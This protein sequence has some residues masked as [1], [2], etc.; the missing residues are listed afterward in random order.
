MCN[1]T[2]MNIFHARTGTRLDIGRP[3]VRR[4]EGTDVAFRVLDGRQRS[5]TGKNS[6]SVGSAIREA[7]IIALV[8]VARFHTFSLKLGGSVYIH[9]A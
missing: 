1:K 6:L 7:I 9:F 8:F 4:A 5:S 2:R 3:R